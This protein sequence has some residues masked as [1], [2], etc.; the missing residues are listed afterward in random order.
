[1]KIA[2]VGSRTFTN[3]NIVNM[4]MDRFVDQYQYENNPVSLIV[5][6]GAKGA[7]TCG[8]NYAKNT[9]IPTKIILPDW[10][11]YGKSAGFK[12]N[13]DIV[14][15]CDTVIAFWDEK[16]KGTLDTIRK[17]KANKKKVYLFGLDGKAIDH[18]LFR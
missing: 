7:D 12:R 18:S 17:A 13:I 5:S 11:K 14:L 2:I 8:E 1:M 6:G 10:S 9:K 15:A 4:T 3:Q 16:S